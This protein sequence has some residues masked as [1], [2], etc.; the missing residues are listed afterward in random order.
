VHHITLHEKKK[1][2]LG[3]IK[4]LKKIHIY[5]NIKVILRYEIAIGLIYVATLPESK[6]LSYLMSCSRL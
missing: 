6:E 5:M 2:L 4:L 3:I 1:I